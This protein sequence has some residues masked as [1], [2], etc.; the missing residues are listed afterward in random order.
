MKHIS[1]S[2]FLGLQALSYGQTSQALEGR[3]AAKELLCLENKD[4]ILVNRLL[5]C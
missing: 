5:I 1:I 4:Q 3:Q 2:L